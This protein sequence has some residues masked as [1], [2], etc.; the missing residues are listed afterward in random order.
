MKPDGRADEI[1]SG[2]VAI[3][4]NVTDDVDVKLGGGSRQRNRERRI[5]GIIDDVDV[6]TE[7]QQAL[8]ALPTSK[9]NECIAF[10]KA[11]YNMRKA[12]CVSQCT[13]P[14]HFHLRCFRSKTD[15]PSVAST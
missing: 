4:N 11:Y 2:V 12:A 5:T 13:Q 14:T 15:E 9:W 8:D 10:S 7:T 1:A 6:G 3:Q